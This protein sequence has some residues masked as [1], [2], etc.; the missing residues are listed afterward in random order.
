[1]PGR[2]I[3]LHGMWHQSLT[4]FESLCG[5]CRCS[6]LLMMGQHMFGCP[7]RRQGSLLPHVSTTAAILLM[8]R[9]PSS[10]EQTAA[11]VLWGSH[12]A[13]ERVLRYSHADVNLCRWK[14][15]GGVWWRRL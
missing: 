13:L 8:V 6:G 15:G 4:L 9:I 3:T 5:I 2:S 1:M 7:S 10:C 14:E 11:L 12:G